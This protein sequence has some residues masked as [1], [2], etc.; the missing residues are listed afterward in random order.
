[1]SYIPNC[2]IDDNYNQKYL[3]AKD[4]E[5]IKGFDWAV[6]QVFDSFFNNLDMLDSDYLETI[7][8]QEIPE[9]MQEEYTMIFSFA[10]GQEEK[11]QV[12]T[13]EDYLRFK[14]LD[15][16][17]SDRDG[18]ITSMIDNMDEKEYNEIKERVD[19]EAYEKGE[20]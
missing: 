2:R 8:K 5:F 4:K 1:M 19:K 16:F 15:W 13:Y 17:E 11:R 14:I 18:M 7:L 3:N 20:E 10:N 12:K 6:E 9:G